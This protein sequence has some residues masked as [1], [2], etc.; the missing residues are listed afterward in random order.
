MEAAECPNWL[1]PRVGG[2]KSSL[3]GQWRERRKASCVSTAGAVRKRAFCE[4]GVS[5]G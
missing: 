3:I 5:K 4:L 2:G 1:N